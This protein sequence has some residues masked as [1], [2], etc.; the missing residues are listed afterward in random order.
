MAALFTAP[1]IWFRE[2]WLGAT[3]LPY[4]HEMADLP[5]RGRQRSSPIC[6]HRNI[7]TA[8]PLED[9]RNLARV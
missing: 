7:S 6:V 3:A 5:I 8:S 1:M 4:V 9:N 2:D